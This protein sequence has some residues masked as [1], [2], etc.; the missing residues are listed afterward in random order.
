MSEG[1]N[2]DAQFRYS[3]NLLLPGVG[4]AGQARLAKGRVLIIGAGGLGSPA[5]L[6]LAAAGVGT[7][8]IMDA[9]WVDESNLQRQILHATGDLGRAK[10]LSA[11]EKLA[12]L[13]PD[14]QVVPYQ[15][16]FTEDNALKVLKG[17][18][19]ALDCTDGFAAKF[20]INDAC[21][22]AKTPFVHAGVTGF[23]GQAMTV[24]PG[25]SACYRCIFEAP[26]P[27]ASVFT[28]SQTGILG[29]VAGMLGT[30]QATE[31]L[32]FLLGLGDLL[33]NALLRIDALSMQCRK[34][35][36]QPNPACAV[37]GAHPAITVP[38][39]ETAAVAPPPR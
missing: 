3:R 9:D 19:I 7:I 1:C 38:R 14:V 11:A 8:G 27:E 15:E 31:A 20:L 35:Q 16:D 12:E 13:N 37:C 30:V 28:C 17:Y 4:K 18:D 36:L 25:Q 6:Y 34:V 10:V 39:V 29:P 32:K 5:A 26:P 24:I 2:A 22:I 33:T 23:A 21:V